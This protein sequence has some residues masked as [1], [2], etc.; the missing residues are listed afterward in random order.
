VLVVVA[1]RRGTAP[2]WLTRRELGTLG[3]FAF[4]ALLFVGVWSWRSTGDPFT[5]PLSLY[6]KRY[7]PFDRLGFGVRAGEAPSATL[8]WDQRV[9]DGSFYEEHRIHT[10]TTL[11]GTLIARARMVGRDMWYDWRGGLAAIAVIGLI[12]APFG[13]WAGLGALAL[14]LGMYLLYAH[15]WT[16]SLYYIETLPV[17]AILTALG[18]SRLN[19]FVVAERGRERG[20]ALATLVLLLAAIY[21]AERTVRMVREQIALDHGYYDGFT[22]LLP[23]TPGG[24]IVFVR[25]ARS[26]NDGLSLVRN[27]VDRD[28]APVWTAYDR[29]AEND[30][31][32]ALAPNRA[33]Y[34]FDESSWS[35]RP[36]ARAS[37]S[38]SAQR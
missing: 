22:R 29:G 25:Y 30:R 35:L 20:F 16:W 15:P 13:L 31:L 34:L 18:V 17:L 5:T 4:A 3:G 19:A 12:G 37:P 33:L 23:K 26:H 24:A 28:E 6:T 8:P 10:L 36:L 32:A 7:V 1:R 38:S 14:Q 11:P 21:P 9:T 27:V 2:P